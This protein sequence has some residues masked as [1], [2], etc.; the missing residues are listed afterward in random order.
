[1][2]RNNIKMMEAA[3]NWISIGKYNQGLFLNRKK[4]NASIIGGVITIGIILLVATYSI[5]L[6]I[7]V[8][9][10]SD[11]KTEINRIMFAESG[12]ENI[13]IGKFNDMFEITAIVIQYND[14]EFKSCDSFEFLIDGKVIPFTDVKESDKSYACWINTDKS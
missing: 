13:T 7:N 5:I 4:E 6:F 10:R 2:E 14:T 8:I 1:M 11:Y 3:I 12:W 9:Y